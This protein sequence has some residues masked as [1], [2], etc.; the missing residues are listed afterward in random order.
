MAETWGFVV[1][2]L[3]GT[4]VRELPCA[5]A[6]VDLLVASDRYGITDLFKAC[7]KLVADHVRRLPHSIHLSFTAEVQEL[8]AFAKVAGCS[9][10]EQVSS[11]HQG[12]VCASLCLCAELQ[13]S[14]PWQMTSACAFT[15][16]QL[17]PLS[18]VPYLLCMQCHA[19]IGLLLCRYAQ[20]GYGR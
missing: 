7:T 16:S 20:D 2:W 6:A 13:A 3:Y 17:P 8:H 15:C 10:V 4:V 5:A 11:I 9:Q 1:G 14:T 12:C 19:F 18:S